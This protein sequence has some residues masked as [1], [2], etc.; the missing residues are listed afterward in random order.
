MLVESVGFGQCFLSS[1]VTESSGSTAEEERL[2]S[3]GVSCFSSSVRV[4]LMEVV[5]G[6]SSFQGGSAA[7]FVS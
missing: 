2:E 1:I 6:F 5:L 7:T 4:Y 3:F